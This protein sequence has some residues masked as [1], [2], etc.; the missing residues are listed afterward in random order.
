MGF[1]CVSLQQFVFAPEDYHQAVELA[2]QLSELGGTV[3]ERQRKQ[4]RIDYIKNKIVGNQMIPFYWIVAHVR[5]DKKR[6]RVNGQHSSEV[7]HQTM[8]EEDWKQVRTPIPIFWGEY[9]CETRYDVAELFE[10]FDREMSERKAP[11]I[12]GV[13]LNIHERLQA[14]NLD[15]ALMT[16]VLRGM[17]W[18]HTQGLREVSHKDRASNLVHEPDPR[19]HNFLEYAHRLFSDKTPEMLA[20]PIVAAIYHTTRNGNEHLQHF[21]EDVSKGSL[22]LD[23]GTIVYKLAEF[24]KDYRKRKV[25]QWPAEIRKRLSNNERYPNPNDCLMTCL[26]A[27]DAFLRTQKIGNVFQAAEGRRPH[28]IIEEVYPFKLTMSA[29]AD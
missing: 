10:Q 26:H 29:A 1:T 18:F 13:H 21:W 20:A 22:H 11:D 16:R 7:I 8:T 15:S 5:Q 9:D 14:L 23:E 12:I 24:L 2:I 25:I 28:V 4:N 27:C 17:A 6:V 3:Y 19:I